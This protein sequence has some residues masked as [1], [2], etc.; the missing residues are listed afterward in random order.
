MVDS[1][2]ILETQITPPLESD[3]EKSLPIEPVPN[4][5]PPS[6]PQSLEMPKNPPCPHVLAHGCWPRN[7]KE[8]FLNL[9][10]VG[11]SQ[12]S[13][14]IPPKQH[15]LAPKASQI[16]KAKN[17]KK[18]LPRNPGTGPS[19][20][21][22]VKA[23]SVVTPKVKP[24]NVISED[25]VPQP[26]DQEKVIERR[27]KEQEMLELM[28]R[29][30]A[31][32]KDQYLNGGNIIDILGGSS[33][34]SFWDPPNSS[35]TILAHPLAPDINESVAQD[36]LMMNGSSMENIAPE[37]GAGP[38]RR[39]M[40]A[41][42][43]CLESCNLMEI[44]SEGPFLTWQRGNV[45]ERLDRVVC[46]ADWRMVFNQ[47][48]VI[49][50][51]LPTFDHCGIWLKLDPIP[52]QLRVNKPFKFL[53][54]WL[55]HSNF[56][57]QVKQLWLPHRDWGQN[58][59]QFQDNI[60]NWNHLVFGNI[61]NQ[62]KTILSRLEGIDGKLLEGPNQFLSNLRVKLWND[63]EVILAREEEYWF[64][65]ARVNWLNLDENQQWVYEDDKIRSIM[66]NFIKNLLT[67][68]QGRTYSLLDEDSFP[69]IEPRV[70][71]S[72]TNLPT[73]EEVKASLFEIGVV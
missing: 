53:A 21:T 26:I 46:T 39:A 25:Q 72:L 67:D 52:N 17:I 9:E 18:D 55:S 14:S 40:N 2:P 28:R 27:Q 29:H 38:N 6:S 58:L 69:N 70:L 20:Q 7:H 24:N 42:A 57:E 68:S 10:P 1:N 51:A 23:K 73:I 54:S 5:D 12:P 60:R 37:G 66:L 49:N 4:V 45:R 34:A 48:S 50:L 47:A 31:K 3:Q 22:Y 56:N 65:Q 43:S 63:Y 62:K 36:C 33:S 41:F 13:S 8:D 15:N 64:H 30:Q 59:Q 61:F 11:I 71:S 44:Q 16:P 32:L 19:K 35:P